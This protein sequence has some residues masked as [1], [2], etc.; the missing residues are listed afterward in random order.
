MMD[1]KNEKSK[2]DL[3]GPHGGYR[4]LKSYQTAEIIYDAT[5]VF[6]DLFVNKRSRTHDQMVQAACSGKQNM[7]AS[8]K[9]FIRRVNRSG[10][11]KITGIQHV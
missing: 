2:P 9:N 3:I 1:K 11:N 8:Q 4:N 6:C 7:A 10:E 5:A